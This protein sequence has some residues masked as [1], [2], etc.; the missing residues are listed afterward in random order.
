MS[1]RPARAAA[2]A[3]LL[4]LA[5]C[6]AGEDQPLLEPGAEVDGG[7]AGV[8]ERV[9]DDVTVADVELP[10]PEDGVWEE[11]EDAPLTLAITNSGDGPVTL[12]DVTG[13]D[14]TGVEVSGDGLPLEVP[15]EDNLYVGADGAPTIVLQ[16]LG[17]SLRTSQ[18][19]PV[20]FTFADAGE[21]TVEAIVASSGEGPEG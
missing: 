11:G 8:D 14:F 21:V 15:E 17:E 7:N 12:T 4:P 10:Y 19:I 3:L 5:A 20:T 18:S 2:L 6:A 16:D 13:P 9:S 1:A